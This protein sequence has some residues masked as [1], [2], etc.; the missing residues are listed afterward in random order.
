VK[1]SLGSVGNQMENPATE[2]VRPSRG[3]PPPFDFECHEED[4]G[5]PSVGKR[6]MP[7]ERSGAIPLVMAPK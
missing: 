4:E 3:F 2:G 6:T 5:R 7:G 1:R